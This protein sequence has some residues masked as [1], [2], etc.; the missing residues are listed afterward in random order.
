MCRVEG[1]KGEKKE[2]DNCNS[3]INKIYFL[4]KKDSRKGIIFQMYPQDKNKFS[5]TCIKHYNIAGIERCWVVK[6]QGRHKNSHFRVSV[7]VRDD[8]QTC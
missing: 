3:I 7:V 5:S 6:E 8:G 4:K 2:W 1:N